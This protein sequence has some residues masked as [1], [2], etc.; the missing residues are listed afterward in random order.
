[1]GVC[2]PAETV[3]T[4]EL[5]PPALRTTL[6][7]LRLAAGPWRTLGVRLGDRVTV[8]ENPPK[9]VSVIVEVPEELRLTLRLVG[10]AVIEKSGVAP[11][12]LK[13]AVCTVSGSGV[14]DPFTM[15]THVFETLVGGVQPV[16][17][18]RGI[19]EVVPVM[20]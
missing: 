4:T 14:G 8:P 6:L 3:R 16:W 12:L 20:L 19:P 17:K 9:L 11:E 13:I 7:K 15:V 1:M 2:L 5:V 10:L 18:P